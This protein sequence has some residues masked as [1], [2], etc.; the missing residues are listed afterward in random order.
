MYTCGPTVYDSAHV[1]HL[2]PP[3]VGDVVKRFLES[4]GCRVK[5]AHNF[6]DVEDKIIRKA[7]ELGTTPEAVAERY[8][9]EYLEV[10]DAMGIDTVDLYSRVIEQMMHSVYNLA[11]LEANRIAYVFFG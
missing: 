8:I 11:A 7:N 2:I 5:W 4:R 3:V 10:M 1:G 9:Q 6:T